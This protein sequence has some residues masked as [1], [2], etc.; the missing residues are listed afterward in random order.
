VIFEVLLVAHIAVLGYWLGSELV[1]NSTY[2]YVARASDM[3]FEQRGR[4]MGHVMDVDQHVRYALILQVGLGVAL[5]AL[6]GFVPGG[7]TTASAAGIVTVL[8]LAFVEVTHRVRTGALGQR[9]GAIDRG[10]R[11]LLMA[12]FVAVAL[13]LLGADWDVPF[14]LRLKLALF[15]GVVASGVGIRLVL[16]S[17]FRTWEI[18]KREGPRPEHDAIIARTATR[19]TALVVLLWVF[20]AGIVI[21]S[22]WKPT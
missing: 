11:Y 13:G 3:D 17:H 19:G 8:W 7:E 5:A 9:L 1:I 16:L 15:A 4:L 22:V 2:R 21:A 10:S 18:M 20:I 6:Y 12:G 14:W